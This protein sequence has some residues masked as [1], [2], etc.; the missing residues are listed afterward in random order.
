MVIDLGIRLRVKPDHLIIGLG[1]RQLR[2]K[3]IY[4][5]PVKPRTK[6][7]DMRCQRLRTGF[8]PTQ[9]MAEVIG[10]RDELDNKKGARKRT[11]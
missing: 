6:Q 9:T 7:F 11:E 10:F 5:E 3:C 1:H 2:K 4:M 8:V